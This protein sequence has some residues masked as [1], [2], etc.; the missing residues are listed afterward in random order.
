MN[1]TTTVWQ[2]LVTV[3]SLHPAMKIVVFG[4]AFS[5]LPFF[6]QTVLANGL[7]LALL[8]A[9]GL[10]Y[11]VPARSVRM[12]YPALAVVVITVVSWMFVNAGGAEVARVSLGKV[13]WVI[14]EGNIYYA[15]KMAI[16]SFIWIGAYLILLATTS[17]RDLM[18]GVQTLGGGQK[19]AVTVGMTLKFWGQITRDI[20]MILEAQKARGVDFDRGSKWLQFGRRFRAAAIPAIFVMLKRFRTMSFALT[21][22]GFA[23]PVKPTQYFGRPLNT[24]DKLTT[25]LFLLM[26]VTLVIFDHAWR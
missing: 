18:T 16:R 9:L 4:V 6:L 17:N 24:A 23:S 3:R 21:L 8:L 1:R 10:L 13:Q 26:L 11:Q 22:R 15:S 12:V 5:V 25:A 20:S 2:P 19:T 7:T 14:R